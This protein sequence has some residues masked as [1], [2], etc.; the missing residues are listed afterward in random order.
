MHTARAGRG[1]LQPLT[2]VAPM[3]AQAS[4]AEQQIQAKPAVLRATI[5]IKRAATGK[6]EEYTVIGTPVAQPEPTKD[7]P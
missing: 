6:V 7:Q 1:A 5:Q 4:P 2:D 3:N